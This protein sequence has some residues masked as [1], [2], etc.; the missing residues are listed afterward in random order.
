MK[1]TRWPLLDASAVQRYGVINLFMFDEA[2]LIYDLLTRN[3]GSIASGLTQNYDTDGLVLTGNGTSGGKNIAW[4]RT[5]TVGG[6]YLLLAK[7]RDT[8]TQNASPSMAFSIQSTVATAAGISLAYDNSVTPKAVCAC[9]GGN[10]AIIGA[11]QV[12]GA[13]S[14]W[15]TIAVQ[16][17]LNGSSTV[18]YGWLNGIPFGTNQGATLNPGGTGTINQISILFSNSTGTPTRWFK[19]AISWAAICLVGRLP[20]PQA[21][22]DDMFQNDFPNNLFLRPKFKRVPGAGGSAFQPVW[23]IP[24]NQAFGGYAS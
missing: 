6:S 19:G 12:I 18:S 2:G 24:V 22:I 21:L 9:S 1:L 4:N 5:T 8:G 17:N 16:A 23:T 14:T 7:I 10:G 13:A 15:Q 11:T 20:A 3:P